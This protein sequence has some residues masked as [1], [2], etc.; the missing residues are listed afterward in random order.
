[1]TLRCLERG[2]DLKIYKKKTPP[3]FKVLYL[4]LPSA[5]YVATLVLNVPVRRLVELIDAII[6]TGY[7]PKTGSSRDHLDRIA[8]LIE[9]SHVPH[10]GGHWEVSERK[11]MHDID[12]LIE[13][14]YGKRGEK[15][16][17]AYAR[18]GLKHED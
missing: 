15:N 12:T 17:P 13:T 7:G 2:K 16:E 1:M 10:R 11:K 3:D 4:L 14:N 5:A 18:Y 6:E 9:G 8:F